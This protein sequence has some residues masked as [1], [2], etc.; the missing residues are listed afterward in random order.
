[1]I[2][3]TECECWR[4]TWDMIVVGD[5]VGNGRQQ[6]LLYDRSGSWAVDDGTDAGEKLASDKGAAANRWKSKIVTLRSW[7]VSQ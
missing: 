1:M 5:F 6:I 4:T 2:P 3:F 7:G